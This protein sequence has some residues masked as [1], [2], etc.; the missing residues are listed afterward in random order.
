MIPTVYATKTELLKYIVKAIKL[1]VTYL[2]TYLLIIG[3]KNV[4][5]KDLVELNNSVKQFDLLNI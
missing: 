2:N 1:R 4:E 3:R 5:N